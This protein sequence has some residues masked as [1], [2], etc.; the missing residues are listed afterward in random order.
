MLGFE[1]VKDG[2]ARDV[3]FPMVDSGIDA[4]ST[5]TRRLEYPRS[6]LTY[7]DV[8]TQ[9]LNQTDITLSGRP[10]SSYSASESA[11]V[12]AIILAPIDQGLQDRVMVTC[13]IDVRWAES[14]IHIST[15]GRVLGYGNPDTRNVVY[16]NPDNTNPLLLDSGG[17][18]RWPWPRVE[19]DEQWLAS[20]NPGGVG[21]NNK[22]VFASIAT[23]A[24]LFRTPADHRFAAPILA[25][26]LVNGMSSTG[27]WSTGRVQAENLVEGWE[28]R[29]MRGERIYKPNDDD[30]AS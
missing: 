17:R 23:T 11:R 6:R 27:F 8:W 9:H 26:L 1:V 21:T 24:G 18:P 15:E 12:G 29:M 10:L 28:K 13:G 7:S 22:S 4:G 3:L 30:D 5:S 19:L 20:L 2:E 25:T 14:E 16:S